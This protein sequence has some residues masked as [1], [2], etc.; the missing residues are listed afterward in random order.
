MRFIEQADNLEEH[1][2][3]ES[4]WL[5]ELNILQINRLNELEVDLSKSKKT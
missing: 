5:N 3:V 4:F 1:K 2:K